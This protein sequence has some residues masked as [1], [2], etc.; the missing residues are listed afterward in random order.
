MDCSWIAGGGGD[1]IQGGW[2]GIHGVVS[3][4][5]QSQKEKLKKSKSKSKIII[6]INKQIIIIEKLIN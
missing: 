3:A 5:L 2:S 6:K 1:G 4:R